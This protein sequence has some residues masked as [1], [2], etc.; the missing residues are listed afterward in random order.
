MSEEVAKRGVG[1]P[2]G[3][4]NKVSGQVKEIISEL[5][6][7]GLETLKADMLELKPRDRARILIELLPFVVPKMSA[8]E[9]HISLERMTE[10]E[11]DHLLQHLVSNDDF[12]Q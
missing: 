12:E 8:T 4:L 9:N 5:V 10:S 1:R 7:T 11:L 6:Q 3:S 2:A